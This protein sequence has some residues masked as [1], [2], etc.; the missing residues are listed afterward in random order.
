M[1]INIELISIIGILFISWIVLVLL[2]LAVCG[3]LKI[4]SDISFK[5]AF[6]WGLLSLALPPV[7]MAYGMLIERNIY[8]VKE[9]EIGFDDLPSS[10]DGY[11]IVHLSDIHARSFMKRPES[12]KRAVGKINSLNADLTA[13]TGDIITMGSGELDDLSEI[14]G[15]IRSKDGTVSVLGNHDYCIYG[16]P[17]EAGGMKDS[18]ENVIRKEKEMGWNILLDENLILTRGSDSIAVI[19]VENTSPS[20]HFPSKGNLSE[21]SGGT[22]GMFRILLSHDPMHWDAEVI[23]KDYPLMLSG[24]THAMQLSLF[25]WSPSRYMFRQY[26]GLYRNDGQYLYVNTGLGETIFPARIGTPPEITLITLRRNQGKTV[27]RAR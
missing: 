4:F 20:G 2:D 7:L 17:R 1:K 23:G 13:F 6:L 21:A 14:L 9:V 10:F 22:E 11:R 19:G 18:V 24:H 27:R 8:Q 16:D 3:L 5:K 12:L 25:G 26:R 15:S